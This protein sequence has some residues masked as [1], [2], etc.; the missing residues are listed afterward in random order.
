MTRPVI[1]TVDDDAQVVSAIAGDLR[2]RFG[3]DYRILRASD[4]TE[5]LVA[6]RQLKEAAEAVALL[7]SDQR[8][9]GLDG[10]GFLAEAR[11]L[12][13]NARR[14][15]LTA[16]ADTDAAI[17]AINRSQVDYYL[18]KPWDP[19]EQ[20]LYP[21]VED[22][23]DDWRSQ[24]RPGY[25]GIKVIGSRFAPLV[26]QVKEFLTHNHVP[27]EFFD[28]EATDERGDEARTL[29]E[30]VELPLV[31]VPGGERLQ[32][33]S[34]GD[35][36]LKVGLRVEAKGT[37]YDV[38]IVG[39]GPAG[40][41]AAVYAASEGLSTIL[42]DRD[43]PGGQA[44]YSSRIEN[45][46]G[47]PSGVSGADLARRALTQARRFEVEV[48]SPVDVS[49]VRLDAPF[50]YLT[51]P[52]PDG[53]AREIACKAL[54]LTPGLAWQ[55]LPAE[56]VEQF[57]GRGVYY[58]AA[59]TEA[60]NCRDQ[61]VYVVGAGNSAGQAAIY[62]AGFARRVMMVV[63]GKSLGEKMSQY[64]VNRI[65]GKSDEIGRK[66]DVLYQTE[67]VVCRGAKHLEGLTL[68]N[69]A[70]GERTSVDTGFLFVFIGAVPRTG[71]L[72][73]LVS[74]DARGFVI[75]GP[76]LD[77]ENHLKNWPLQRSPYLL[78]A[79][80]PGVF[81]AGDVRHESVKRVASAVGEGSVVVHFIHRYLASL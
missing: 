36:A 31:I 75:T 35:L 29:A 45:Y 48:V 54:V 22:L 70:S 51:V 39:A 47:F 56:C 17:A 38:A 61:E 12:F 9:P 46:L 59:T 65:E 13:P 55:R 52:G 37:V 44:G 62:L 50:K 18:Q 4:A 34:V 24:Y 58:G 32:A 73:T 23:L 14:A 41:A 71:W 40:L 6:L 27:Y 15:L 74:L 10:V 57:E 49:G 79:S 77:A 16:Y 3:K 53:S 30:G 2:R 67:V 5:A 64:L 8:M 21:V 11:Q 81:A 69:T 19:P 26:H 68:V 66:I 20:H 25:G 42:L 76:D 28:V 60:L 63:R 7:L 43:G 80:V 72:G 78:E 33:P 1:L